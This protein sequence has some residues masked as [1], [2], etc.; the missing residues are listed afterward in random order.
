MS[1]ELIDWR[2]KACGSLKSQGCG[3][4]NRTVIVPY[5]S[6]PREEAVIACP[7]EPIYSPVRRS[8]FQRIKDFLS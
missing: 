6:G 4:P 3:Q 1:R 2:C 8:R 7:L 5:A